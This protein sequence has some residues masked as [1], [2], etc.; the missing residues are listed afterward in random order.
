MWSPT[1][2]ARHQVL[3]NS[4][5]KKHALEHR[6]QTT[7]PD[8]RRQYP[9]LEIRHR[10]PSKPASEAIAW[11]TPFSA[12]DLAYDPIRLSNSAC[13]TARVATRG[14]GPSH[15]PIEISRMTDDY[16]VVAVAVLVPRGLFGECER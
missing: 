13:G 1:V 7:S 12:I 5:A 3:A 14:R 9:P 4:P 11:N 10:W 8:S 2:H 15:T 16:Y 6:I